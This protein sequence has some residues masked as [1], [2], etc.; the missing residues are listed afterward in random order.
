MTNGNGQGSTD[1]DPQPDPYDGVDG[2]ESPARPEDEGHPLADNTFDVEAFFDVVKLT[3]ERIKESPVLIALVGLS[4]ISLVWS[5]LV[6]GAQFIAYLA[7][8][9]A[10]AG[11]VGL[12]MSFVGL[13]LYPVILLV[14]V[15]QWALYRPASRLLFGESIGI[16]D[17]IELVKSTTG[18]FLPVGLAMLGYSVLVGIG[19]VMCV[20]PG[21]VAAVLFSQAPYLVAVRDYDLVE[22]FK[23]SYARALEHWHLVAMA[24]GSVLVLGAGAGVVFGCVGGTIVGAL[25]PLAYMG[26]PVMSWLTGT[27]VVIGAFIV[28]LAAFGTID[29]LE[30]LDEIQW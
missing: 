6:G 24:I 27:I 21:I 12:A 13:I 26:E 30:G 10:G 2:F 15:A 1:G 5:L 25:G 8:G 23:S 7:M 16:E 29:E 17:P 11:L 20:I 4:A 19:T 9:G 14:A 3:F 22:S 28:C 18:I